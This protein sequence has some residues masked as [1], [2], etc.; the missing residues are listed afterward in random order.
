VTKINASGTALVYSTYLGG[1]TVDFSSGIAVDASGNAYVT[2]GTFSTNFP[3]ANALQATLTG[4][5]NA[6][7]TKLNPTGSALVYSTYLGGN[8]G[9][10]GF[11]FGDFGSGI[12]AD[13]SGNAYVTGKTTSTNFPTVNALQ[14]TLGGFENAFVTKI[15]PTGSALVYSTYLGGSGS[16]EGS[17]IAVDASGN[18]YITGFTTSTNFPT[19]N[20]LQSTLAGIPGLADVFVT[21]INATG[22]ALVYSTYLGG[23]EVDFGNGIAVDTSGNAYVTGSTV[24]TNFPTANAL[25]ATLAGCCNAFVTKMNASGSALIYSTYLGGSGNGKFGDGGSS[26]AVDALGNAYVTG[27]TLST[28]FPTA[29][30]LQPTFGGG[31]GDAFVTKINPIGSALVYSTYLGGNNTDLA[32]GI[33]VDACGNAYM[34]GSTS[35]TNFPTANALQPTLGGSGN[36]FVAKIGSVDITPPTITVSTNP[37]TLWPPNGEMV[38]VTVSGEITDTGSGVNAGTAKYAVI[39][40][41]GELQPSGSIALDSGGSYSFT[42]LLEASRAGSDRDGRHY[43]ITVSAKDNACNAGSASTVVTVPHD[44]RH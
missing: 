18:V 3:T 40:E 37:F 10:A 7:V 28:N 11:G 8:G 9:N 43:T 6:F 33:A 27:S 21:K 25:Q 35:S 22:S 36:A 4:T 16:D 24:S 14:S 39:D 20:A 5:R 15:N 23:S 30:A 34:I 31:N 1:S 41:Y 2:G 38:P 13:A 26:I 17:S 32:T 42:I 12:V 19:A 44:R 29:N